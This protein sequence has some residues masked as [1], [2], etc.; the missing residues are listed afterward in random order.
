MNQFL[1]R[2]FSSPTT[3][4]ALAIILANLTLVW[5]Y[6]YFFTYSITFRGT[7][8]PML[9]SVLVFIGTLLIHISKY[10]YGA[11]HL[12]LTIPVGAIILLVTG[13]ITLTIARIVRNNGF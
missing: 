13:G 2:K 8:L 4:A 9:L 12:A 6:N 11:K 5:A 3:A 1:N 7:Y 10:R